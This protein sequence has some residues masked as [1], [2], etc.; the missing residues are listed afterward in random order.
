MLSLAIPHSQQTVEL[1]SL[2]PREPQHTTHRVR[3]TGLTV[4]YVVTHPT[5]VAETLKS[6]R[7]LVHK[8]LSG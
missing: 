1:T 3:E 6:R 8:Y 5:E 7:L 2:S 4:V